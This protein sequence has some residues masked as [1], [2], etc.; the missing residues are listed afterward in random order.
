[1]VKAVQQEMK[2]KTRVVSGFPSERAPLR[3]SALPS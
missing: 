2:R 3:L 1:M